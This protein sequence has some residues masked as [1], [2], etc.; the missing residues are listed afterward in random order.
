VASAR[1]H[2]IELHVRDVNQ[3]F[4]SMDPSPYREKDL[5]HAVDEFVVSW[6]QEYPS[7]APLTLRVHVDH[8]PADDPTDLVRTAVHNYYA[9]RG[10][11]TNLE[12]K[13]LMKQGRR[14]LVIGLIFLALCLLATRMLLQGD[15]SGW[16]GYVRES[17]TIAGWVAMWRPM[18]IYLYDW[19]PVRRRE[20]NYLKLSEM[21]VD[22]VPGQ[23]PVAGA[24][25]PS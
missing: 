4:N 11:L 1:P 13:R 10:D 24:A 19:W 18:E 9:Y 25:V 2:L 12:F 21:P 17:L 16:V 5:D 7:E 14:S 23:A 20:R 15:T 3:L 6:A 8:W 22:V